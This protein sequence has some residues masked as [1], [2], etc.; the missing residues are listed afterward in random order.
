MPCRVA[1]V[2]AYQDV[3]RHVC[4]AR[5]LDPSSFRSYRCD[6]QYP[7]YGVQYYMVFEA[8]KRTEGQGSGR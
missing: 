8:P 1:E 2:V 7:V 5:G 3:L 6:S 4:Q